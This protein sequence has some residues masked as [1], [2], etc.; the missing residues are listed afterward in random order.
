LHSGLTERQIAQEIERFMILQG[1]EGLAFDS[2]VASG[3]NAAL[4]HAVPS[5]RQIAVGEPITLD[6]GAKFDG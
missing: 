6:M 5:D 4:P 2:I 3:P 1:A